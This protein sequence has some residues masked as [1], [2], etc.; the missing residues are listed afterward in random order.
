M[1]ENFQDRPIPALAG[2]G[3]RY[4]HYQYVINNK[5]EIGWFEVHSENFFADGGIAVYILEKVRENYPLS[6]HGVGLSLGSAENPD[7]THLKKLKKL[8]DRFNPGLVSE[9][10]SWSNIDGMVLN[11]LFPVPY[12]KEAAENIIENIIETQDFLGRQILVENPSSYLEFSHST[13]PEYE[14][15][16]DVVEKSRCG[17][18]LDVNN[19]YVSS[20]NH[21][22]DAYEYL[23]NIPE[24]IVQEIHLAGHAKKIIGGR[25]ILVDAHNSRVIEPVWDLY[26]AAIRKFGKIPTLIEWDKDIPDFATLT[27]ESKIADGILDGCILDILL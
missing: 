7:K 14:F 20:Q 25:E 6:F 24:G 3:L 22:A 8:I 13:M 18:L 1:S 21:G 9:H 11:D 27:E 16:C 5:P 10:I 19:I 17:L 2:V 26:K 12:T 23:E 4:L 15:V